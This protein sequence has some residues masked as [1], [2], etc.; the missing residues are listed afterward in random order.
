MLSKLLGKKKDTVVSESVISEKIS[1]MN[2]TEMRSYV[3]EK[4][5][6][7]EVSEEGLQEV[8]LRLTTE[9][10]TSKKLYIQ[11]SDMDSKKKKAFDLVIIIAASKKINVAVVEEIQKFTEVYAEIIAE[12]DRE[13][14]EIYS[15][16]FSKAIASAVVNIESIT[17]LHTKMHTLSE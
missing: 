16:R 12:Y 8:I 7:F 5:I 2:L 13:F 10:A 17:Q 6:D 14:K 9:D 3:K 4:I 15:S 11:S 1:K